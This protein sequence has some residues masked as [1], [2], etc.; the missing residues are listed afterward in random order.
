LN[1]SAAQ[2]WIEAFS[3]PAVFLLL[4]GAGLGLPVSEE[5]VLITGGVVAGKSDGSLLLMIATAYVGVM[6]GDFALFQLG[7][8]LG[9]RAVN[10]RFLRMAL[11]PRRIGWVTSHFHRFGLLTVFIARFTIGFR[12][13]TFLSAGISGVRTSRF[14]MADAAAA[15]IYVPVSVWLGWRF[16]SVVLKD[17]ENAFLWIILGLVAVVGTLLVVS[18]LRRR[19]R[20]Q[21]EVPQARLEQLQ[22]LRD[23]EESA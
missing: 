6:I 3:Y 9:P 1:L 12:A 20:G 21:K 19:R 22:K 13:V 4:L 7:R 23:I 15:L 17:V 14:L 8:R 18:I 11:T 5:V 2:S 16:G 10:H